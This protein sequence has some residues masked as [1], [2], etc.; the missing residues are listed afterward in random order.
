VHKAQG[1][2]FD[3]VMLMLPSKAS[4]VVTR[5]LLYTGVTRARSR[6]AIA[7]DAEVF[8]QGVVSRTSRHSG[9]I[10]RMRDAMQS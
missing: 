9:L 2:E 1:S 5:E 4:R 8:A 3:E 7:S 6:V 10:D